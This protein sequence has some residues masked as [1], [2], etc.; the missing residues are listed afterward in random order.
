MY[1]ND[2]IQ[3]ELENLS[4]FFKVLFEKETVSF[5]IVDEQGRVSEG[6]MLY[7]DLKSLIS[8]NRINEAEDL[9]FEKF[10]QN[11]NEEY[12]EIAV[13]FYKTCKTP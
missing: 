6:G 8:E 2:I 9:L 4:R 11:P 1:Q 7:Y 13:Q 12:L 3:R 10:G 5:E